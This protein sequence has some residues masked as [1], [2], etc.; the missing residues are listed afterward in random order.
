M[1]EEVME[2]GVDLAGAAEPDLPAAEPVVPDPASAAVTEEPAAVQVISVEELLER[3]TAE[4]PEEEPTEEESEEA[5]PDDA[6]P[7]Q[8]DQA[9]QLLS[10]IREDVS[11]RPFLTTPFS[12]YTVTEGLLLLLALGVF[13]RW[14]V[15]LLKE[16]FSWLLS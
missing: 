13:A 15:K 16:G 6:E 10:E 8:A 5:T 3:L 14:L 9:F 11:S 1:E 2:Y 7:S 4:A 12:E